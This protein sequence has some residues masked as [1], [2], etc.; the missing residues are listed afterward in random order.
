MLT[1]RKGATFGRLRKIA[2]ALTII[3]LA[4]GA[5]AA[6]RHSTNQTPVLDHGVRGHLS[7]EQGTAKVGARANYVVLLDDPAAA[8]YEGGTRNLAA[9]STRATGAAKFDS[10]SAAVRAYTTFLRQRQDAVLADLAGAIRAEVTPVYRYVYALNGFSLRLS[11]E[12]AQ[13]ARKVNGVRSVQRDIAYTRDTDRGPALI[14]APSIWNGTATGVSAQG[15]GMVVGIMDSGIN[16]GHPSFAEVGD[17]GYGS[18]GEYAATNPFGAGNFAGGARD[19]CSNSAFPG[20]C[21]N[22]L[23][24]SHSFLDANGGDDPFA[25]AD[26]PLSKDTDGHGSHVA[27]TAAGNRLIDPPLLDADGNDSGITL[28]TVSG[29]APHAHIIAYKVCAPGCFGSDIAAAVDQ[30][31]LDGADALN[32]SIGAAAGSPWEDT[33]SLAFK[34]AR[35]AGIMLQN[36]AGNSGPGAGTAG[37]INASPWATGV[38]A[39][40]HDRAFPPKF[41]QGLSGGDTPAP[42]DLPGRSVTDAFTGPIVYAGDFP[43]GSPGDDNFDQPEQC[44]EAFPAG[45]FTADQIVVC[46]RGAIARVQKARNVRDGG[47]GAMVLANI[48]GGASSTNDDVH[49]IP[50]IHINANDGDA[51]RA[52]LASGTGHAG[53]ITGTGPAITDPDAAD[54]LAGFSSRGPYE[55]F[56]W[57]APHVSAPGS[58]IYA[59]GADLQFVHGGFATADPNDDPSVQGQYGIISGTSMSSPHATGAATLLKQIRPDLTPAEILSALMTTGVTDMRKEDGVTPADPF[60]Y[61]GG[62][63]SLQDAA[64]AALVLD[65]T[66]ANFDAADPEL[67]GDP[68]TLNLAAF[69]SNTCVL[70]CSWQRTV[71]NTADSPVSYAV[72]ATAQSGMVATASPSSFTLGPGD[73]Q[74]I[75]VDVD[76]TLATVGWNFGEVVLE[77]V[78]LP[79]RGL[80]ARPTQRIPI[81]ARFT[82]ATAPNLFNKVVSDAQAS[83]GQTIQYN[84]SLTNVSETGI[85]SLSDPLPA[86]ADLVAGSESAVVNGGTEVTPFGLDGGNTL[87]WEGTLDTGQINVVADPFPPA[88]SPFGYVSLPGIG[89]SP[90]GCSSVCDDTTISLTSLPPF[91]YAGSSYTGLVISS[92]GYIVPGED[93]SQAFTPVNQTLPDSNA[94]NTVIAPFWT[95]LDLDGTNAD[96]PGAGDLYAGVFN[97]GQFILIEWNGAELFGEPGSAFTFQI[98]IGTNLAPPGLRGVWFVYNELSLIPENLTVGAESAAGLFGD[99]YYVDGTGTPPSTGDLGDLRVD[100]EAGGSVDLSFSVVVT[101]A[102]GDIVLNNAQITSPNVSETAIAIT[103]IA[104]LD[105]D[106]D[107]VEDFEDNCLLVSN[108]SQCDSDADGFGNHCD[109][110]FSNNGFVNFLDLGQLRAGFFGTSTPPEYNPLDMNCDGNINAADLAIFKTQFGSTPGPSAFE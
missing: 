17:D 104:F 24:G 6:D 62:R 95:D 84:L 103:E 50:A 102:V 57:L 92:N 20:L 33:K 28:G 75:T 90:L 49:V 96:D 61:G 25:P 67:G 60:D 15:E 39:S 30:A 35:A 21:N 46:D 14:G 100:S 98:Q 86:N 11:P 93:P 26:D 3:V 108:A 36:S 91:D 32:H 18:G 105:G 70:N 81:A 29:V 99:N 59:A 74:V 23:I 22:K 65:E 63:V 47:A 48:Q 79:A 64:R 94:P 69:V 8:L 101:G 89:V 55:G 4:P 87:V 80:D 66:I 88:G 43:V 83:T 5:A 54:I 13:T 97:S 16:Q 73:T 44:L 58:S 19:D 9:T 78:G 76:T 34:G 110:D 31:I 56:D 53:T 77:N 2:T 68:A 71:R 1:Y 82:T 37:R 51:L 38:A 106:G 7:T 42:A 72:T 109:A 40:T 10:R 107:G 12:Q 27:S 45:T 52:W 41:L 85:Y